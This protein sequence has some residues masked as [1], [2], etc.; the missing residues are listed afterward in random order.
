M[1]VTNRWT[2]KQT[3]KA[4]NRIDHRADKKHTTNKVTG[5]Q[6][7]EESYEGKI[8]I[9]RAD[10]YKY[11]G[12]VI[13]SSGNNMVNIRHMKNKSLGVIRKIITKLASLNL[14][15]YY[16]ECGVILMNSILRGTILY[17]ADM[18]YNLKESEVR[19]VEK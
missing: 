4:K 13:S 6:D 12:F 15:K 7:L 17:A 10:E 8:D 11:L 3:N 5:E 1:L 18:Y 16:F 2:N 19:G 9:E 14:K